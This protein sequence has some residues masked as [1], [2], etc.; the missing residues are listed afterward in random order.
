MELSRLEKDVTLV[1]LVQDESELAVVDRVIVS[2]VSSVVV[3]VSVPED[4]GA[5]QLSVLLL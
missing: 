2:V 3:I 5:V 4:V 1:S